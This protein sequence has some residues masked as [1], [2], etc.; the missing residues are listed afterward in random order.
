MKKFN[1]FIFIFLIALLMSCRN[2]DEE[3]VMTVTIKAIHVDPPVIALNGS[4]QLS[5][6]LEFNG[7]GI[8]KDIEYYWTSHPGSIH[9][10]HNQTTY[11]T[12][13]DGDIGT[14]T[15]ILRVTHNHIESY[16]DAFIKVVKIPAEGWG[17]LSGFVY[18][19]EGN[20]I[21]ELDVSTPTG[22]TSK[23]AANGLFIISD[24]PQ[25]I[26]G[27]Y[28]PGIT[29]DWASNFPST[30]NVLNG[31]HIHLGNLILYKSTAPKMISAT[32]IPGKRMLVTWEY[33]DE[34]VYQYIDIYQSDIKIKRVASSETN[35]MIQNSNT[36]SAEFNSKAIPLNGHISD[37]S[38]S[39]YGTFVNS[40]DPDPL[41][42]K[43]S[44][45]DF[46]S[47]TISWQGI[48][49]ENY[50]S[51]YRIAILNGSYWYFISELLPVT[52]GDYEIT[53]GP[54]FNETYY[55]I[56][57]ADDG[58]YNT[59]QPQTQKILVNVSNLKIPDNFT[60]QFIVSETANSLSW[61][62]IQNSQNWYSGY[63]IKRA[64]G[65]DPLNESFSQVF[66]TSDMNV[67][68][69]VDR[70]IQLHTQYTYRLYSYAI[71]PSANDTLFSNYSEEV[72]II[73]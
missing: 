69:Y 37:F 55:V 68:A 30:I 47:A 33:I 45:S 19:S 29:F 51:G 52:S 28:F 2:D 57:C 54:G 72:I 48:Y 65:S 21:P 66:N 60:G 15:I 40:I 11:W 8:I 26:T 71:N 20:P 39:I 7:T 1:P 22:E 34:D 64:A 44:Y 46:F 43:V 61:D 16:A 27:L 13:N 42:Y 18:N 58:S 63:M 5:C 23:T 70:A 50:L 24:V 31:S 62:I 67:S 32:A 73:P 6:D 14:F 41:F 12:P 3:P 9:S 4:A 56:S 17:S 35:L 25:G 59:S 53:T 49:Y 36:G 38:N 10:P